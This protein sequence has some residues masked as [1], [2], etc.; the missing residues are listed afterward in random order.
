[1]RIGCDDAVRV[2]GKHHP[3]L[4]PHGPHVTP[5]PAIGSLHVRGRNPGDY[6]LQDALTKGCVRRRARL[7]DA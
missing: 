7:C 6:S 1:V 5:D 4:T 2:F 3:D